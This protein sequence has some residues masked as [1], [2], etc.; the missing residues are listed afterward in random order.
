MIG[1]NESYE[2]DKPVNTTTDAR[3]SITGSDGVTA[4]G[5]QNAKWKDKLIWLQNVSV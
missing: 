5:L 3:M 1:E 2:Q 4:L